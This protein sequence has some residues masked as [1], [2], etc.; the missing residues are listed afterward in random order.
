MAVRGSDPRQ[1]DLVAGVNRQRGRPASGQAKTAAQR[2]QERRERLRQAGYAT[3]TVE[4]PLEV[5][6]RM[7]EFLRFKDETQ[8]QLIERL[9]R[10]QLLRKR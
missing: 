6:D 1:L 2:Q 8:D 7:R 10:Q 9:L 3:L 5:L 4:L